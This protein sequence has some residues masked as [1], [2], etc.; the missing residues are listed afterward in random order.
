MQPSDF[1]C[2][3]RSDFEAL[4][5]DER[6]F[7]FVVIFVEPLDYERE[8]SR[9][10][11]DLIL[12]HSP[13][14]LRLVYSC[15]CP[16]STAEEVARANFAAA[17]SHRGWTEMLNA[18]LEA[19]AQEQQQPGAHCGQFVLS[20]GSA[21][22]DGRRLK[23]RFENLAI[24][25]AIGADLVAP[26]VPG[27]EALYAWLQ[28]LKTLHS[29]DG[30]LL[31]DW[32]GSLLERPCYASADVCH[33]LESM[34]FQREQGTPQQ[35]PSSN[36]APDVAPSEPKTTPLPHGQPIAEA[37]PSDDTRLRAKRRMAY[38]EP[39]LARKRWSLA[40]L[41]NHARTSDNV[42]KDAVYAY[43][44]GSTRRARTTTRRGIA[45]AL[46]VSIADLPD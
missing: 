9:L 45:N 18:R 19:I 10:K 14:A 21:H 5:R 29:S 15:P 27:D 28:W 37:Q 32:R 11:A 33:H 25:A 17:R 30:N 2:R 46:G 42:N 3:L 41:A 1:W 26:D 12:L 38:I 13:G 31:V 43:A 24:K 39:I 36:L 44:D 35:E 16:H 8:I 20:A 22:P 6:R 34:V 23:L 7:D 40:T 4:A